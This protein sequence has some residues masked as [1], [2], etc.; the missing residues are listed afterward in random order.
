M[1]EPA[2]KLNEEDVPGYKQ[3][4][5]MAV[6]G[7]NDHANRRTGFSADVHPLDKNRLRAEFLN[8]GK[9][10]KIETD[11]QT[12]DLPGFTAA[13]TALRKLAAELMT[14]TKE[15]TSTDAPPVTV[16]KKSPSPS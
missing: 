13:A 14:S 15:A 11:G 10:D 8:S 6:Q 9:I 3:Q 5:R 2:I 12:K 1:S 4:F 16:I 7:A